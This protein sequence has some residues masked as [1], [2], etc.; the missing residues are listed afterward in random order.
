M[1][2]VILSGGSGTRLWP[3]SRTKF[4]KQFCDL[5]GSPMQ[6]VTFRRLKPLGAPWILTSGELKSL[7]ETGL[8]EMGE[9]VE[10]VIYETT[11]KNTAAA[12]ALLGRFFELTGRGEEVV[13]VFPSDHVVRDEESFRRALVFAEQTASAGR[14][15]TLGIQPDR[16]ETG[17]GYI[18]VEKTRVGEADGFAAHRVLRFHEKPA[19][20]TARTFLGEG[21]YL[22]NAGIFVFRVSVF[23]KALRELAPQI[24]GPFESLRADLGNLAEVVSRVP[25][26]SI[27]YALMEKLGG[28][29]RLA[30]VPVE[31]GW[32]DVGSWDAVAELTSDA[33][34]TALRHESPDCYVRAPE[35]KVVALVGV[36]GLNVVDTGDCLLVTGRG[37]SQDV[38]HIVEALKAKGSKAPH[39][40]TFE[41]RPWGRFEVLRDEAGFKSKVIRVNAGAQ[42]SYQSHAQREEH[43]IVVEGVGEV[44]L[45]D[46]VIPVRKGTYVHIPLGAKH[47]IRNTAKEPLRFVE[48]QL[49]S[50]F[51][52]DDIVR[53]QDDYARK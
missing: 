19:L 43:W 18:Q 12:L 35:G 41:D 28:G 6:S 10:R 46:K 5:F 33:G 4:P 53:Y 47:R 16:P 15:V 3:V 14:I 48:V 34:V 29:D 40:N 44:V 30:C 38:K 36:T 13:G 9:S 37:R 39:E 31:I 25:S 7:T 32:N 20:E 45:D 22:W 42:I 52:E 11:P 50:Y 8:R 21:N 23:M 17:Y 27:D 51:G 1:I 24:A 49:G 2:P 26:I